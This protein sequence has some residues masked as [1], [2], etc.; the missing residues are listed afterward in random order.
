M[1]EDNTPTGAAHRKRPSNHKRLRLEKAKVLKAKGTL[2]KLKRAKIQKSHPTA[3][4]TPKAPELENR[5]PKKKKNVLDTPSR[6]PAK[7]RKRQMQKSWLP[8]HVWHAKRAQMT[9]PMFPLWRFAMPLTPTEKCYRTTHRAATMRGCV[10]WDTSFVSTIGLEGREKSLQSLFRNTGVNEAMLTGIKGSKWRRGSRAYESWMRESDSAGTWIAPAT[11]FWCPYSGVDIDRSKFR[12]KVLLR[13]HPSAFF[14]V[15]NG[16]LKVGKM[17]Q[18]PVLIE[19]LRFELGSIDIAGPGATEALLAT[20]RPVDRPTSTTIAETLTDQ[21]LQDSTSD[22]IPSGEWEDLETPSIVWSKLSGLTNPSALPVNALLS[23]NITDPRL[24]NPLRTT[25]LPTSYE[26]NGTLLQLLA[27]WPP[28]STQPASDIYDRPR[29]LTACRRLASQKRI[30]RRKGEA[31]P[32]E[33]PEA[34]PDDPQIP[35]LLHTSRPQSSSSTQGIWRLILPWDCVLPTWYTLMHYPLSTGGE[36]RFGGLAEQQQ[37]AFESGGLWFPG[38]FPGTKAGWE[39]ELREREVAKRTWDRKPKGRRIEYAS[40]DLGAGRKGEIG[41]GWACDWEYLVLGKNAYESQEQELRAKSNEATGSS[42]EAAPKAAT[43]ETLV[44]PQTQGKLPAG[45]PHNIRQVPNFSCSADRSSIDRTALAP[46]R[47]NLLPSGHPSR[48]ARIYRLPRDKTSHDRWLALDRALNS[49]KDKGKEKQH[50]KSLPLNAHQ[51]TDL[52]AHE[53]AQH[54]ASS[55]LHPPQQWTTNVTRLHPGHSDY[56]PVPDDGD[57]IGFVTAGNY[58][59]GEGK[60]AA[61]GNVL[62]FRA[63]DLDRDEQARAPGASGVDERQATRQERSSIRT[64]GSGKGR[65]A[66]HQQKNPAGEAMGPKYCIVRDSGQGFGRLARWDF[67]E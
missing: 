30:N 24:R 29:R 34:L 3:A 50:D 10:A 32:G 55:L 40:V 27:D 36:P 33:Y 23:F 39:W 28:D 15:W 26:T 45:P 18:P 20:L 7:F 44:S 57:L 9:Q 12:R 42:E 49:K 31:P 65:G 21:S 58:A 47:V 19:D 16:V 56:P 37:T 59:L 41:K 62:I 5:L 6:P 11:I 1:K 60:A 64:A 46:I 38:D 66:A 14:Q 4:D 53:R 67:V 22:P 35:V 25:P 2:A 43:T 13:V 48:T 17:Q 8:T 54:L 63:L 52:P 61:V 51:R